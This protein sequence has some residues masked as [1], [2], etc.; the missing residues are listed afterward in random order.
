[1]RRLPSLSPYGLIQEALWPN[2][3][4]ILVSCMMLNCTSR[5]QVVKVWPEFVSRFPTP[6]ALLASDHETI[7]TIVK[8]LGFGDRRAK[9]LVRMTEA[10]LCT[11]WE[12][13]RELPG[14][15]EYGSRSWEIFVKGELGSEPPKDHALVIYWYWRRRLEGA[16]LT[17][18]D[19]E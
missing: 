11:N 6:Q 7:S 12:H 5:K 15:G 4:L 2:E 1:M 10:Y 18:D 8:S 19:V 3:W 16:N 17:H 13:A 9:N 14:I